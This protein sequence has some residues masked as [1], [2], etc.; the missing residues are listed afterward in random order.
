RKSFE[1]GPPGPRPRPAA[2]PRRLHHRPLPRL[3]RHRA[4]AGSPR[5]G[6]SRPPPCPQ[7]MTKPDEFRILGR[8][9]GNEE[10]IR[11]EYQGVAFD[12]ECFHVVAGLNAVDTREYTEQTFK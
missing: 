9:K 3:G 7:R 8:R 11:F 1:C 4:A 5:K 6:H 12:Q 2:R 10:S